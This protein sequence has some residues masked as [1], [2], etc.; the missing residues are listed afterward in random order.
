MCPEI[1]LEYDGAGKVTRMSLAAPRLPTC[2]LTGPTPTWRSALLASITMPNGAVWSFVSDAVGA[3]TEMQQP[4]GGTTKFYWRADGQIARIEDP[5]GQ[6]SFLEY[7]DQ[8]GRPARFVD[9]NGEEWWYRDHRAGPL[10]ERR[11]DPELRTWKSPVTDAAGRLAATVL[12]GLKEITV[13][14]DA[15]GRVTERN[16]RRSH[17]EP[18]AWDLA[19]RLVERSQTQDDAETGSAVDEWS[20]VWDGQGHPTHVTSD[21]DAGGGTRLTKQVTRWLGTR[22]A[23]SRILDLRTGRG[24][25]QSRASLG[26]ASS[27]WTPRRRV[28]TSKCAVRS[29]DRMGNAASVRGV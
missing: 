3:V 20:Y 17:R 29:L 22:R 2:G 13:E 6:A 9:A 14:R 26:V 4:G 12:P 23:S 27:R 5:L 24:S 10:V 21:L 1:R 18:A 28:P 19:G 16:F 8:Q 11:S 25:Y 15:A 7:D